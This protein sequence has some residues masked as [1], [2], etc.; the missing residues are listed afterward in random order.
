[1]GRLLI[2]TLSVLFFSHAAFSDGTAPEP[3]PLLK[4][5]PIS[6]H[7]GDLTVKMRPS[8]AWTFS[9]IAFKGNVLTTPNSF[10][11]LVLNFGGAK[12]LGLGHKEA[13][14]QEKVLSIQL[15]VDGKN[16]GRAEWRHCFGPNR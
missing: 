5:P 15:T 4:A 6:L 13:G 3:S 11:G 16:R 8:T 7:S 14:G 12:F 2:L 10:S 9:E 1:M